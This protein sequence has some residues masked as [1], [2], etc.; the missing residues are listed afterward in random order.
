MVE[1]RSSKS[2]MWVQI[3]LSSFKLFYFMWRK[4]NYNDFV[5]Y[6]Y[7]GFFSV[8][9]YLFFSFFNPVN[10]INK[11]SS[12]KKNFNSVDLNVSYYFFKKKM[13]FFRRD[14]FFIFVDFY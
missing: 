10:L 5:L 4:S 7:R 9:R 12:D 8:F 2:L 3:L 11:F 6:Y 1:Q 13:D 14:F